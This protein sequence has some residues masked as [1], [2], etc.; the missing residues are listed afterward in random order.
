MAF[1]IE[2]R[3]EVSNFIQTRI[4]GLEK[5]ENSE[6]GKKLKLVITKIIA[7][8]KKETLP[9]LKLLTKNE[10]LQRVFTIT[11]IK[12]KRKSKLLINIL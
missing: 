5:V 6:K 9:L 11:L 2:Q 1:K 8:I 10:I 4:K 3:K 12:L 7:K